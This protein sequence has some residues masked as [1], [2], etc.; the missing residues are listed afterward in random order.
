M[1]LNGPFY[2]LRPRRYRPCQ[3]PVSPKASPAASVNV[4]WRTDG[5]VTGITPVLVLLRLAAFSNTMPPRRSGVAIA[6]SPSRQ[7][8]LNAGVAMADFVI[9]KATGHESTFPGQLPIYRALAILLLP[10]IKSKRQAQGQ[11]ESQ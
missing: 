11:E 4:P 9:N 2:P 1:E 8:I 10:I 6:I 7:V 5:H 3:G